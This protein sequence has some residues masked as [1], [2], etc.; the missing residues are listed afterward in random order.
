M[1]LPFLVQPGAPY[2]ARR[3][4]AKFESLGVETRP[5]IVGNLARQPSADRFPSPFGRRSLRSIGCFKMD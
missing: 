2:T 4:Q 5:I 3:L 1:T